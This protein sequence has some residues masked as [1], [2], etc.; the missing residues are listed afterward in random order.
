MKHSEWIRT[1]GASRASRPAD[2]DSEMLD[3][4]PIAAERH[5]AAVRRVIQRHIGG[6]DLAQAG[7]L[8]FG[9]ADDVGNL[10]LDQA[11]AGGVVRQRHRQQSRQ[12]PADFGEGDCRVGEGRGGDGLQHLTA[13]RLCGDRIGKRLININFVERIRQRDGNGAAI[14]GHWRAQD[15]RCAGGREDQNR[16]GS[17]QPFKLC[18]GVRTGGFGGHDEQWGWAEQN[19]RDAA[20]QLRRGTVDLAQAGACLICGQARISGHGDLAGTRRPTLRPTLR[21]GRFAGVR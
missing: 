8:A 12:Q 20:P 14:R 16:A 11:M 13:R 10:R 7:Y 9:V 19:D 4:R 3:C 21:L 6:N 5:D 2:H 15:C 17:G 18:E 1:S